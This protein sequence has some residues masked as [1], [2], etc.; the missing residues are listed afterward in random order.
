MRI[1]M[2]RQKSSQNKLVDEKHTGMPIVKNNIEEIEY[3]DGSIEVK[4]IH[5]EE[6]DKKD[7]TDN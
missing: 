3:D 1:D 6:G 2:R 4:N 7:D 5:D